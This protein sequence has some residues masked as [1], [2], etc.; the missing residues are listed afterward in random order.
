M[1]VFKNVRET[2]MIFLEMLHNCHDSFKDIR[3]TVMI[4]L[5]MIMIITSW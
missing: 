3:E 2:L 4:V 1:I 5:E